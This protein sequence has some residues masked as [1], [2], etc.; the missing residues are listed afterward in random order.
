MELLIG[1]RVIFEGIPK[2]RQI[3]IDILKLA[4]CTSPTTPRPTSARTPAS[5][6]SSHHVIHHSPRRTA[7]RTTNSLSLSARRSSS[8]RT[9]TSP[10]T[11]SPTR[12]STQQD[13]IAGNPHVAHRRRR[14]N[15]VALSASA[16]A[17][18][19]T[20]NGQESASIQREPN[21]S[22]IIVMQLNF[23]SHV[24]HA[25]PSTVVHRG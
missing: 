7:H 11:P 5:S 3:F 2:S 25:E 6:R 15:A 19:F 18:N 10:S 20:L 13:P 8:S 23:R 4:R 24:S 12:N 21:L 1:R 16:A 9:S 22:I 17:L 14:P